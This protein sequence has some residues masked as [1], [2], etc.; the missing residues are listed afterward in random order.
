MSHQNIRITES[1]SDF[2]LQVSRKDDRS[3]SASF[4][5]KF[6]LTDILLRVHRASLYL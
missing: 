3:F 5:C 1:S 2:R 4:F 6:F